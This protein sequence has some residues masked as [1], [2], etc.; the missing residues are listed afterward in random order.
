MNNNILANN[1]EK[2]TFSCY[3][4]KHSGIIIG[5]NKLD[6]VT[7]SFMDEFKKSYELN[8]T[9]ICTMFEYFTN[10]CVVSKENGVDNIDLEEI[11]TGQA[12]QGIDGIS[13]IANRKIINTTDDIDELIRLNK[14]LSVRFIFVQSKTSENFDNTE[15]SNFLNFV[16]IFFGENTDIFSTDQ[17]AKFIELKDYIFKQSPK[18]ERNP[19][20]NLYYVTTGNWQEDANLH[21]SIEVGVNN[22]KRTNLFSDVNFIPCGASEIQSMFRKTHSELSATFQFEKRVTMYSLSETELGYSGVIPFLEYKKIILDE[23][24]VLKPVFEDNIRDF[25]GL[26]PDVNKAIEET[27]KSGNINSFSMLNNGVTIVANSTNL[28]GD[29]MTIKDYQIV[30]GCQTSHILFQNMEN[31]NIDDLMIPIRIIATNDENLKNSIT[32]ATNN[33]TAIKK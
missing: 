28:S 8:I 33:Q 18:L 2:T 23:N 24:S 10:F 19:I 32:K 14:Q 3:N 12:T 6:R 13:I 27:V 31:I 29:I 22:L 7:E 21:A 25:L 9:D 30:N 5:G 16:S 17:M 20:L 4:K 11:Y 26:N 1:V 15:I